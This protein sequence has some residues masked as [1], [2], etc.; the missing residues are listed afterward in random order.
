MKYRST[1]SN[2]TVSAEEALVK[3]LA[4]DGG[5]YVPDFLPEPFLDAQALL[6]LSYE[7]LA[8]FVLSHFLT[9]I[10]DGEIRK[11]TH[12]AYTGTF[13]TSEIVPVKTLS[14][15]FYGGNVSW[16][17]LC[18]QGSGTFPFPI[19]PRVCKETGKGRSGNPDSYRYFRRYGQ[20]GTGR[21]PG[22]PGRSHYG[23]LSIPWC[24]SSTEGSDAETAGE[25]RKSCRY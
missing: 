14:E 23:F 25:Q 3:G 13:E 19:P 4:D 22:C 20:G 2:E 12:N 16:Q 21:I 6:N 9:D 10:P 17:N 18:F 15:S 24:F 7:E 5:L 8:A 1:R 11:L